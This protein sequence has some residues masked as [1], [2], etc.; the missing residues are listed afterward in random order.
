MISISAQ[1]YYL[2]VE[3]AN[4]NKKVKRRKQSWG[5]TK[6]KISKHTC[7]WNLDNQ[8]IHFMTPIQKRKK[9]D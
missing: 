6:I 9:E 2:L 4:S 1:D 7:K 8:D 3:S 5:V